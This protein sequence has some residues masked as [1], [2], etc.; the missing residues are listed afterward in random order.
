MKH[1]PQKTLVSLQQALLDDRS[2]LINALA[3]MGRVIDD[4]GDWAAVPPPL[5]DSDDDPAIRADRIQ[6]FFTRGASLEQ[7]ELRLSEIDT[8]LT[9][10]AAGT[11]GIDI[12][13]GEEIPLERLLANPAAVTTVEHTA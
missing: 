5:D 13:S 2:R 1:I 8:A 10:I 7:L 9:H 3:D 11:Y 12:V 6:E 4:V